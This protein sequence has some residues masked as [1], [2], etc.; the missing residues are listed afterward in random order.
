[1]RFVFTEIKSNLRSSLVQ[2]TFSWR[3]DYLWYKFVKTTFKIHQLKFPINILTGMSYKILILITMFLI[4]FWLFRL[5]NNLLLSSSQEFILLL[6]THA[7]FSVTMCSLYSL[8]L[9]SCFTCFFKSHPLM[10]FSF[11]LMS[12]D[13][14]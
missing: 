14:I 3:V 11:T 7:I 4:M 10:H 1:M 8:L 9:S 5:L 13:Y 12:A 6:K 2:C